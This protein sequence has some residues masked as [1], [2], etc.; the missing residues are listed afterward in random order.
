MKVVLLLLSYL[1][2]GNCYHIP[3]TRSAYREISG[4]NYKIHEPNTK[5]YPNENQCLFYTGG[6]S[7]IPG[8]LY[9]SFLEKLSSKNVTVHVIN[10]EIKKQPILLKSIVNEHPTTILAHSSGATEALDICNYL[11]NIKNVVLLDPVDT[12]FVTDK[13]NKN[14]VIEP[15]YNLKNLI[16]INAQKSYE[17]RVFPFKVPFIPMFSLS[18][19]DVKA[20]NKEFIT[21]TNYGHCDILD[22]P[23]GKIMHHTICEG[24]ENRDEQKIEEYHDWLATIISGCVKNG[25]LS[26][27]NRINYSN[28][29]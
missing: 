27:D 17:W 14:K 24:L 4:F 25:T 6:S 9:S 12:R 19:D 23:W 29:Q 21:A 10:P 5:V 28:K 15:R 18:M 7:N 20:D 1:F 2:K 26:Y 16:M 8:E 3:F 13:E 22:Y 11:D